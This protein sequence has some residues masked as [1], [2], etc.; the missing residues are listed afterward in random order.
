[1]ALSL[2]RKEQALMSLWG[3]GRILCD[4][5]N[6]LGNIIEEKSLEFKYLK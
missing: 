2:S 6:M 4:A 1:M 3:G 5:G